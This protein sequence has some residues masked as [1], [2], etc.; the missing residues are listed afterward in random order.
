MTMNSTLFCLITPY[1]SVIVRRFGR[2]YRLNLQGTSGST[3]YAR[4]N[5]SLPM[6]STNFRLLMSS[7]KCTIKSP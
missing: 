2:K 6:L 5:A 1:S 3:L 7:S 4:C